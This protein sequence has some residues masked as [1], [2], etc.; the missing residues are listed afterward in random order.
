MNWFDLTLRRTARHLVAFA[1]VLSLSGIGCIAAAFSHAMIDHCALGMPDQASSKNDCCAPSSREKGNTLA[2]SHQ[3]QQ[4]S[5]SLDCCA[6][7]QIPAI[8]SYTSQSY[9]D[10]ATLP[11]ASWYAFQTEGSARQASTPGNSFWIPDRGNTHLL[12]CTFLI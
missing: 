8:Q 2:D 5:T 1:L 9:S 3:E 6:P 12:H 4:S 7:F 11:A 10:F